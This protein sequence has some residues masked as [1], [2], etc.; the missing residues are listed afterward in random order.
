MNL[1]PSNKT[2]LMLVGVPGSGKSTWTDKMLL[3]AE[4]D[5]GAEALSRFE[6]VATDEILDIISDRYGMTYN[7]LFDSNSYKFAEA[8]VDKVVDHAVSNPEI[9]VVVWD[10]TNL[11]SK[12]RKKK[13]AKIPADWH[14]IAIVFPTPDGEEHKRRLDSRPGKKIPENV[15]KL[16]INTM[17]Y[18]SV[19]EGFDDIVTAK[20]VAF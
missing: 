4:I 5:F 6:V 3:C 8:L 10:Q 18:P 1:M 13:L 19:E 20:E 2:L 16:M 7:Q 12:T 17:Q 14:K 15:L 9:T 11:S